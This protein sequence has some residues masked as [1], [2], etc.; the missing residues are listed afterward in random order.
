MEF[1]LNFFWLLVCAA[2]FACWGVCIQRGRGAPRHSRTLHGFIAL[3][4]ALALLLP[5]ISI[6]DDL[7][8]LRVP[9]E[10]P[11]PQKGVSRMAGSLSSVPLRIPHVP[12]NFG[13][14]GLMIF[15][16]YSFGDVLPNYLAATITRPLSRVETRGPPS[17]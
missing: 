12:L 1:A 15:C 2:S 8:A 5:V 7:A 9:M 14:S 3:G 13:S 6:T 17:C 16:P 11:A 10:E 4:F